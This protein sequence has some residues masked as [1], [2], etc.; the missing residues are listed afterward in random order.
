V[1][2]VFVI[3]LICV[4]FVGFAVWIMPDPDPFDD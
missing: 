3:F 1:I 2:D 4:W